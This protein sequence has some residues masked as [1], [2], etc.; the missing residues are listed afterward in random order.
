MSVALIGLVG[1]SIFATLRVA[2]RS[3]AAAESAIEPAR[4][5]DIVFET[6][7]VDLENAQPPRGIL[8]AVTS[9][10]NLADD[11]GRAA[12]TML[13]YTTAPGAQHQSGDGGIRRVEYL[14]LSPDGPGGDHQLVRRAIHNLLS[15]YEPPSDDEVLLRDVAGFTLR[16]YESS[17]STWVDTWDS[18]LYD[19]NDLPA[20]VE[21]TLDIDRPDDR[22]GA[23]L[24]VPRT[25]RY[26]R[27]F[28]L[29]CAL[30]VTP[31]TATQ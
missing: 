10:S 9:G 28:Q 3:R 2:V 26:V 1:L 8:A 14:V 18:T 4:T 17:T 22:A 20:A 13:F 5:A 25:Y 30:P 29:P 15:P 7:R 27:V 24:A 23:D 19:P 12:G 6:L 21:V 31:T 11:R 16:F